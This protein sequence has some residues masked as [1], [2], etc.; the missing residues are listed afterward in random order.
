MCSQMRRRW[1]RSSWRVLPAVI[2]LGAAT[3]CRDEA[4]QA[5]G[6]VLE[7]GFRFSIGDFLKAARE[8]REA[9][10]DGFL[11][12]GMQVDAVGPEG[13]TALMA[14]AG[15]GWNHL[16]ERL[17]KAGASAGR[18]DL[19]GKSAL[20]AAA[21]AGD[22][23]SVQA[24]ADGG[25]LVTQADSSGGT[26]LS[27]AAAQGHAEVVEWL[28][29][30]SSEPWE[31]VLRLACGAGHTGVM[32]ALL[33][34]GKGSPG[35]RLDWKNYLIDSAR[36]GHL[37]A[38][39][40][41]THRM[42]AGPDQMNW[43]TEAA[44]QAHASGQGRVADFLN[45]LIQ[46]HPAGEADDALAGAAPAPVGELPPEPSS[47]ALSVDAT[48]AQTAPVALTGRSVRRLAGARFTRVNCDRMADLPGT[49]KM[50]GWEPQVWPVVLKDVAPG[51]ESAEI[52]VTGETSKTVTLRVG[53]EI[54]GTGCV[55]EKLRR[56]RLYTDATESVLRN[57][58]E[59]SFRRVATGE[60]FRAEPEV[61]VLS[62]DSTALLR[63]TGSSHEWSAVPGDEFRVGSLLLRVKSIAAA[64]ADLEN[65]LT[66]ETVQ[67]PLS[68]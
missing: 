57:A 60:V 7:A 30:R 16:V 6:T 48:E 27:R 15:A 67:L 19:S 13:E 61:P 37:P 41:L 4:E 39:Q 56:R 34:L 63:L 62:N 52:L 53:D 64:V 3:A 38:V 20:S 12:A 25:A 49:M 2:C 46:R 8:G 66:R 45:D 54:P 28:A 1:I 31:P 29:A 43:L 36:A 26:P 33:N 18:L 65:R 32:D 59:M 55:I 40:L 22:L 35:L 11:S 44:A 5:R 47:E 42:P 58:S 51:H 9:V 50:I 24:L 21:A 68:K 23:R 14:A 17:L 10:V